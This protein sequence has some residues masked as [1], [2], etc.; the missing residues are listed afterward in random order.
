MPFKMHKIIFYSRKKLNK[1]MCAYLPYLKFS[2]P[3]LKTRLFFYLALPY[4][5]NLARVEK[6]TKD[7]DDED[8]GKIF[9]LP[10]ST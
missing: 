3:L 2:D 8:S 4:S 5:S 6:V 7:E 9:L 1:N 10:Y